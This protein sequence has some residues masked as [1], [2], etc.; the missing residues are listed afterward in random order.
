VYN[1]GTTK[2]GK[3][4]RRAVELHDAMAAIAIEQQDTY[5]DRLAE[6]CR[7][8]SEAYRGRVIFDALVVMRCYVAKS[9][10][11]LLTDLK[12]DLANG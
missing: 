4:N 12:K 7:L 2:E 3:V 9:A 1:I 5:Y 8:G 6:A 10:K 11:D